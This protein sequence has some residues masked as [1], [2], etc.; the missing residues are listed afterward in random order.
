IAQKAGIQG[1]VYVLAFIDESGSVNDV[2]VLKGIG[3]GCDEAA[4]DAIKASKF[5]PGTN[6]GKPV[7]VKLSLVIN[8]KL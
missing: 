2:K 1:K 6:K 7:K 8:F 3:G 4:A 5:T